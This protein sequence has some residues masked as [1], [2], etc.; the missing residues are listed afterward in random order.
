MKAIDIKMMRDLGKMKGQVV[1]IGFVIVGGVSVYVAMSSV[2]D[3]L[4]QTL[5]TYYVEYGFADGFAS[6]K[7]A[8]QSLELRLGS[9]QGISQVQTRVVASVNLEI[10]G[11]DEPATGT[12]VSIP[13]GNQTVLNRLFIR[14]GRLSDI[15]REDE[16]ILNEA[17]ADAHGLQLND[18][19]SVIINGR[20]KILKVTAIALSPEFL[21]QVQPGTLFPDPER[22]GVMW[23]NRSGLAAAYDM[24]GTFNDVSFTLAPGVPIEGVIEQVDNLLSRYGGT[25]AYARKDQSSHNLI[26]EELNQLQ[27]MAL[28]FP[29]IILAVAAFLLNIV[30]SRLINL[31]REQAA[32]LKAFGYSNF[33]VGLHYIKL[34]LFVAL[35][36]AAVGIGLGIWMGGAMAEIYLEYFQF[37]FLDYT[38]DWEVIFTALALTVGA[39][40]LGTTRSVMKALRLP[41]AE[42]M[43]PAAPPRFRRTFVEKIGLEKLLDQP[44]RIIFRNLERQ[45]IKAL[46]TV[47]GIASSCAILVMGL[48][49]G[50]VM[51]YVIRIQYGLAQREDFTVTFT[52]PTSYS[53]IYELQNLPGVQHVE[54]FRSVPVK[55]LNEYRS[56]DTG[57]QGV[58]PH[59]Y[60]RHVL[61]QDLQPIRIPPEGLVLTKNLA[62]NLGVG[63]GDVLRVEVKEGRRYERNII[64]AGITEQY[65]G[66]GAYMSLAAANELAGEGHAV[67]G[68]LLMIDHGF[69]D[70][71]TSKLQ[72]KPQ[73]ASIVSQDRTIEAFKSSSAEIILT[74]TFIL[75]LFAGTVALGVVYNSIR[76]SLSERDRELASLRV[77]GFTHGEISYILLGEMAILVLLA[78]P[79]GFGMGIILG[80]L[81]IEALQTD[82]YRF[83]FIM[84]SGTLALAATVILTAALISAFLM[85]RKL[86]KLDLIGVLK[87]RE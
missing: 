51:A 41:P 77:L 86:K 59:P 71:L 57:I 80:K 62:E 27:A 50:D 4:K 3:T 42:A 22:Y 58:P 81:S 28:M 46:L 69:E 34:V 31:Q 33:A 11:F 17:F 55:L 36:G 13:D 78:I 45:W 19:F 25:G 56:Y 67:S 72:E 40:L 2:A 18:E 32:I 84:S 7:R 65:L 76:I 70:D 83:P 9:I 29:I 1:A 49:W 82:L 87:T 12:I 30:V 20:K 37:P 79:L 23:M 66:Q 15:D 43:K 38:I 52:A 16:V 73:I 64:V 54:P 53:A 74:F 14:Q 47:V 63:P 75:S 5:Q 24:E 48:F 10:P 85:Y 6:V 21:Y 61:N 35:T 39:T 44:S 8:P 68:A 60:L 26:S